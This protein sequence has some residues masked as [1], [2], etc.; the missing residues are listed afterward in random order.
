MSVNVISI[1]GNCRF[2]GSNLV[3]TIYYNFWKYFLKQELQING[4]LI[5]EVK[6]IH[7]DENKI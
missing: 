7:W 2:L 6:F 3:M 5:P 1:L 4:Y